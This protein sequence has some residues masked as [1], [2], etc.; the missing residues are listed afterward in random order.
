MKLYKEL[1]ITSL[2]ALEEAARADRFK[3]VKGLA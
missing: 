2:V 3:G 1:G